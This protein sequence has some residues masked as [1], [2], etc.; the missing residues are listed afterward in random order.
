[1]EK[2]AGIKNFEP[3]GV[4]NTVNS[5]AGGDVL[6]WESIMQL[7]YEKYFTKLLLNKV[8]SEYQKKYQKLMQKES[9]SKNKKK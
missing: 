1:M 9:E 3:F 2:A 4:I 7:P 6:K 8:E 5:L